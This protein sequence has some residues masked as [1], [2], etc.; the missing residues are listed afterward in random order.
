MK[1]P[2]IVL[3][4]A[5]PAELAAQD[6]KCKLMRLAEWTVRDNYYRPVV[7]GEINGQK[8]GVLLDTGAS[9]SLIR[10]S[11][12]ARLNLP[13]QQARGYQGFGIGGETHAEVVF[14]Q[15]FRIGKWARTG[16]RVL[17]VGEHD[18]GDDQAVLLGDDFFSQADIEFDLRN[19]AVRLF[20]AKDCAGVPL[21]YWSREALEVSLQGHER[22]E[23]TVTLNGKPLRTHLDSGATY[24]LLAKVEAE[25]RGIT[26]SSLGVIPAGCVTGLGARQLDSWSAQFETF[27]IGGEVI[28][29]PRIQFADMWRDT[30]YTETGSRLRQRFAGMPQMLLGADFLRS[31]RVL[32]ARSQAKMYFTYEGGT[33]FPDVTGRGCNVAA[34]K[35]KPG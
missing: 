9:R 21:A 19:N 31:H 18:I 25:E 13:R 22:I 34:E 24:S 6:G 29:N 33:V 12:T 20:Q 17:A 32:V 15:E 14:I 8:V 3:A 27:A 7:D 28:R 10:R 2:L 23:F 1:L 4:L 30:T 26:P 16:W 35:P 11:A 5:L